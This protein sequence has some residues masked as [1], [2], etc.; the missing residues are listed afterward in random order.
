MKSQKILV[1][2]DDESILD[3]ISLVLEDEGFQVETVTKGNETYEKVEAFKPDLILLD[4]LMSGNDGRHICKTLKQS[5]IYSH[6]PIIMI[7]A[8]PSARE[9]IS[10]C[11]ADA[12]LAK[13]FEAEDLIQYV[14][15]H[16]KLSLAV[17][18]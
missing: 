10:E 5:P 12:F 3:A 7:S 2:D 6:I 11:G 8:H 17:K 13:P 14:E 4:V 18:K 15:K 16:L 9:S 1:V